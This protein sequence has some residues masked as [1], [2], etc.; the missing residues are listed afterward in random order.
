MAAIRERPGRGG[1]VYQVEIRLK[2]H[3]PVRRTFARRTDARRWLVQ[4]E[5][6]IRER[7]YFRTAETE[8]H[9]LSELLGRYRANCVRR[10]RW[11]PSSPA[12][13]PASVTGGGL[14]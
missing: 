11:R 4:T 8:K 5:A 10:R 2:G 6:A 1:T 12:G 7:R 14:K 3:R 13:R 9:I